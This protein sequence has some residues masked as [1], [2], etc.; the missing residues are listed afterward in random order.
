V[1]RTANLV[2]ESVDG[3]IDNIK[4]FP[5]IDKPLPILKDLG[6]RGGKAAMALGASKT[7]AGAIKGVLLEGW[8]T[9]PDCS[10]TDYGVSVLHNKTRNEI[11][12][13]LV[14]AGA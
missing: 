13:A 7:E 4:T 6:Y 10:Y 1:E 14:L 2:N 8:N 5:P 11:L 12:T 9:I 3:W